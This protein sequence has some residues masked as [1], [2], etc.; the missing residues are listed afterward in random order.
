[1]NYAF[2]GNELLTLVFVDEI[3]WCDR[4][5]EASPA[6]LSHNY[7]STTFFHHFTKFNFFSKKF[8]LKFDYYILK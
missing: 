4:S 5:N 8:L 2:F 1:M 7:G 3:L 6:I